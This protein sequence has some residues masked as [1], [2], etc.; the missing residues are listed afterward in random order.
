M[1][2]MAGM[3]AAGAASGA[4]QGKKAGEAAEE[5]SQNIAQAQ[6]QAQQYLNQSLEKG[7]P[8]A[9]KYL[10]LGTGAIKQTAATA[11]E[12]IAAADVTAQARMQPFAAASYGGLDAYLDTLG[13][14]RP[15]QGSQFVAGELERL[16]RQ[17]PAAGQIQQPQPAAQQPSN[18]GSLVGQAIEQLPFQP[19]ALQISPVAKWAMGL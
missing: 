12:D 4:M 1:M 10:D 5:S 14:A 6:Q 8:Y 7:I 11:R 9:E 3:A 18:I 17:Q 16:A 2:A 13:I 15:Q 19:K